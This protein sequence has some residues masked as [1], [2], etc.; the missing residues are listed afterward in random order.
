MLKRVYFIC[1]LVLFSLGS[2]AVLRAQA[3]ST[4][5]FS[6]DS[7]VDFEQTGIDNYIPV[8]LQITIENSGQSAQQF[9]FTMTAGEGVQ[10]VASADFQV[11]NSQVAPQARLSLFI[12][13]GEKR[14]YELIIQPLPGT[15]GRIAVSSDVQINGTTSPEFSAQGTFELVLGS[16]V[17][18][19][20]Q[21]QQL[22]DPEGVRIAQVGMQT[23]QT[24][25]DRTEIHILLE[26]LGDTPQT[27]TVSAQTFSLLLL[28]PDENPSL[29]VEPRTLSLVPEESRLVR[30]V[31]G[32]HED[33]P[34]GRYSVLVRV[35]VGTQSLSPILLPI[36]YGSALFAPP[37]TAPPE[38][39]EQ[40]IYLDAI[41]LTGSETDPIQLS[42]NTGGELWV[43][44]ENTR[45]VSQAHNFR[46][47]VD[48]ATSGIRFGGGERDA[49]NELLIDGI[50]L[51]PVEGIVIPV[52]V[53][54]D[55]PKS[56]RNWTIHI[57]VTDSDGLST[58]NRTV[59]VYAVE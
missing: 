8:P 16:D 17:I 30:L 40:D 11:N 34:M 13:V 58:S 15:I 43:W 18:A 3:T 42:Q 35:N 38:L 22:I 24:P 39:I 36:G 6:V 37:Q 10:F 56:S 1:F 9:D 50:S 20:M 14:R 31:V 2:T 12:G 52:R 32:I 44:V 57:T 53:S 29:P 46:V 5:S 48:A 54:L 47:F 21:T 27:Y 23:L 26:N 25:S 49:Q 28:N 4:I 51:G 55:M 41:M 59:Q 45:L 19:L 7:F 33:A